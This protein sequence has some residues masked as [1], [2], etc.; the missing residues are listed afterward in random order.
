MLIIRFLLLSL[1]VLIGGVRGAH[2]AIA[3]STAGTTYN[4]N[5]DTLSTTGVDIP[6]TND[7]TIAG[8]GLYHVTSS[9]NSAPVSAQFYDASDG[10][11]SAGRFFS[12]GTSSD[13]ALGSV[14][15]PTFGSVL[16]RVNSLPAN[17]P[18][19]W[20]AASFTNST[21]TQLTQF[22]VKYDGE[23]WRNAGDNEPPSA[24]TMNFEYGFGASFSAV[25]TW[26]APGSSFNFT[27]PVFTTTDGPVDGNNAGRANNLGGTV[28]NLAWQAGQTLWVRWIENNDPGADAGLAIDNFSFSGTLTAVPEANS[29]LLGGIIL[30][31]ICITIGGKNLLHCNVHNDAQTPE[32]PSQIAENS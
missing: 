21:G 32:L 28:T 29:L 12:F 16:D 2:A 23:Q 20:V 30:I 25:S 27:S 14:G 8:W 11:S 19:G 5:F 26:V 31:A 4:Q 3:Y 13:R 1:I 17:K 24:Q 6:W 15:N 10:S 18:I 7:S 22:T 9:T